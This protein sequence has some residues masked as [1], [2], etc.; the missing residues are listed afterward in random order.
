MQGFGDNDAWSGCF[1][2][3]NEAAAQ[4]EAAAAEANGA[5]LASDSL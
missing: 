1:A 5:T 2:L 4:S 3:P